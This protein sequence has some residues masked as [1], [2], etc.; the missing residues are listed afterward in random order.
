M[1]CADIF[2]GQRVLV[3]GLGDTGLSCVRFLHER[4]VELAVTDSR[5]SP[6]GLEKLHDEFPDVGAFL[7][8]FDIQAI[9]RADVLLLSPGVSLKTPEIAEAVAQG[10]PIIG[11]IEVFARCVDTPVVA[12]TGSNGKSTVTALLGEMARLARIQVDIGG[13]IGTPALQLVDHDDAAELFVLELSSF[14]LETTFS[15]NAAA[16]VILNVSEDHMD[17]YATLDE[18]AAAKARIYHGSGAVVINQDDP[19]VQ[20]LGGKLDTQRDIYYFTLAQP[21]NDHCF[22]V[23]RVHGQDVL[24]R[25]SQALLA[26]DEIRIKGQHNVANALAC[27]A[28]G[29]AVKLPMPAMLEALRN[30]PGLPHR[31]QWVA[32]HDGVQWFNDSKATNVGAALAAISGLSANTLFVILGGQGKDQDFSPLR[33]VLAGRNSHALLLGE[34]ADRIAA[35]LGDRVPQTRV[36]DMAEAVHTALRLVKAGDVVLLSPACASFDMFN[37]YAHRGQVFTRLVQES[38][39]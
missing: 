34:D 17:R 22:G 19:Y 24:A 1:N 14:Q 28:L 20:A 21:A 38:L 13:N 15:L 35:A 4:G 25:G 30:F 32:E 11:D 37:G 3:V 18:Y 10:K 5:I 12:I 7:G 6:P 23:M 26:V 9:Q 33:D 2:A 27:L 8:G 16:S 31:M 39:Q 29:S 36:A